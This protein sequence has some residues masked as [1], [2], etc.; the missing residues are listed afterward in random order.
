MEHSA[1]NA[2]GACSLGPNGP[3]IFNRYQFR[4]SRPRRGMADRAYWIMWILVFAMAAWT[5][6]MFLTV[7]RQHTQV[8]GCQ[9][10]IGWVKGMNWPPGTYSNVAMPL[11][12]K[13]LA[14]N[15]QFDAI[16]LTDG[17]VFIA[18]KTALRPHDNWSGAVYG[19]GP[20]TADD[21]TTDNSNRQQVRFLPLDMDGFVTRRINDHYFEIA[22]DLG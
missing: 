16:V 12:L 19:S 21:L 8:I 4:S 2:Q 17:R 7:V 15:G 13:K 10:L 9:K 22:F 20:I 18:I 3:D 1:S 6:Q 14:P 11:Q 5:M